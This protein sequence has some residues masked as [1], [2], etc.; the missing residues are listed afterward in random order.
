MKK[1]IVLLS[2]LL[3]L[4]LGLIWVTVHFTSWR[5]HA[6]RAAFSDV[7]FAVPESAAL[8]LRLTFPLS[9]LEEETS[10]TKPLTSWLTS[11]H[12]S[13]LWEIIER[14]QEENQEH[15][16]SSFVPENAALS[17]HT[18]GVNTW[19]PGIGWIFP[20]G[21]NNLSDKISQLLDSTYT[22]VEERAYAQGRIVEYTKVHADSTMCKKVFFALHTQRVFVCCEKL[23]AEEALRS[24][25]S[26]GTLA[27]RATLHHF[28]LPK[29]SPNGKMGMI[30]QP[31]VLARG[32]TPFFSK[33]KHSIIHNVGRWTP[34]IEG[35]ILY[36]NNVLHFS[37]S[38]PLHDSLD[39]VSKVFTHLGTSPFVGVNKLPRSTWWLQWQRLPLDELSQS[40]YL[41]Y[42]WHG[43][44]HGDKGEGAYTY[45][46]WQDDLSLLKQ[47]GAEEVAL[48]Y[49]GL[50]PQQGG[51]IVLL[52]VKSESAAMQTLRSWWAEDV[53]IKPSVRA[54]GNMPPITQVR[55]TEVFNYLLGGC[56][57]KK[58]ML[59]V[60]PYGG[61]LLF[62]QSREV[63]IQV[64]LQAIRN[65]YF[66]HNDGWRNTQPM[67]REESS[68][69]LYTEL[70]PFNRGIPTLNMLTGRAYK[71]TKKK[72]NNGTSSR[73]TLQVSAGK[74]LLFYNGTLTSTQQDSLSLEFSKPTWRTKL[75]DKLVGK[76]HIMKSHLSAD[77][78]ILV[79]DQQG[80]LYLIDA[81]GRILWEKKLP[82]TLLGDPIQLDIYQNRKLQYAFTLPQGFY[83]VDR[84]GNDVTPFPQ[85]V[86]SPLTT[87]L[88]LLDY[89]N[90]GDYRLAAL[91]ADKHLHLINKQ[92]H[93][94]PDFRTP[95]LE[96]GGHWALEHIR[97]KRKDYLVI[98]DSNRLY[99]LN[100]KGEERVHLS[101]APIQRASQSDLILD[102]YVGTQGSLLT[103]TQQG[104]LIRVDLASGKSTMLATLN[105][106]VKDAQSFV[107]IIDRGAEKGI[108]LIYTVNNALYA[109]VVP[110]NTEEKNKEI[111]RPIKRFQR[112]LFPWIQLF[113]FGEAGSK[114]GVSETP[115]T[116]HGEG[117]FWLLEPS[118][119]AVVSGFPKPGLGAFT[120]AKLHSGKISYQL[121]GTTALGEI[122]CYD[123]TVEK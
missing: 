94:L 83:I 13:P 5:Y 102:P 82:H 107:K 105:G 108:W 26:E 50:S 115:A 11:C 97:Y 71:Q 87:G 43:S 7:T 111:F 122:L 99:V 120:I 100:R 55:H 66:T 3:I 35:E 37:G 117:V 76:P 61:T 40:L 74:G 69:L 54:K 39:E 84:N 78:E 67:L 103:V 17:W 121:L 33:E 30:I 14:L 16:K 36:K 53:S 46:N 57:A 52:P 90:Q 112:P 59:Y 91:C 106:W 49:E 63:L 75:K 47:C 98:S 12:A 9:T 27:K 110:R 64:L 104:E 80:I 44:F 24:F 15:N 8:T 70:S 88:T 25:E 68:F 48:A 22:L 20:H 72:L 123:I 116:E 23:L 2:V 86:N 62:S 1:Q 45:K 79:Q 60:A 42:R 65:Q 95:Q 85:S 29:S 89:E 119:G 96:K 41:Q 10:W 19:S 81:K 32:I 109:G 6:T 113:D 21:K 34:A 58:P 73:M 101:G 31:A 51:W 118:T 77:K 38:S 93:A 114:I 92:G 18:T 28:T 4:V 56:Y